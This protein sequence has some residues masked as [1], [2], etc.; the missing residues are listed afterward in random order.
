MEKRYDGWKYEEEEVQTITE[1]ITES[2]ESGIIED[3]E[4]YYDPRREV[5]E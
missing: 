1:Q 4:S 5:G 2:Y 3:D